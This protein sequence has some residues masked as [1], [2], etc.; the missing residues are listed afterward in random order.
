[1]SKKILVIEDN[2]DVRENI[3]EILELDGYEVHSASNGK[4]GV[5][6]ALD[7]LPDLIL[8]DIMMP[9]LDGYGT[10]K[11]LN[12]NAKTHDIPFIFLTAKAEKNDFRKGMGLGADDYLTKPFDDTE[13]LE[14][15]EMRMKK[16][17][18]VEQELRNQKPQ[19]TY[20]NFINLAR[21]EEGFE[22]LKENR[23]V[24]KF[25]EKQVIYDLGATPRYLFLIL[26]GGVKCEKSNEAGKDLITHVYGQGQYF[27]YFS[28]ISEAPYTDHAVALEDTEVLLI[29]KVEFEKILY[30]NSDF[31][32]Q[33]I[34]ML[35]KDAEEVEQQLLDLA[36][37][38]V[39]KKVAN[40]LLSLSHFQDLNSRKYLT[41]SRD[42]LSKKAGIAKET[43][44]RTL[45]DFKAEGWI[46]IHAD[47]IVILNKDGLE[48]LPM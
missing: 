28:L 15:I 29:P 27:G 30:S 7:V 18:K 6:Q 9:E 38:S 32:S 24:R 40:T 45:S 21:A 47:G 22:M 14:A 46:E 33:F 2:T 31:S 20:K 26:A 5:T 42:D 25:S 36:Y 16:R 1:M 17:Q 48:R 43:L 39:R 12:R 10:L 34:K 4:L 44:I 41:F 11:I 8:C 23:E 3:V 13:L 35:V 19:Q 37:S